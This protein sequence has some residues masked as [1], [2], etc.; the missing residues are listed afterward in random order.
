MDI[1]VS[2][3][4]RDVYGARA[5][6]ELWYGFTKKSYQMC[7]FLMHILHVFHQRFPHACRL[8]SHSA[9]ASP[10]RGPLRRVVVPNL[11]ELP[12]RPLEQ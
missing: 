10:V 5:K 11:D 4:E 6:C 7:V 1:G 2:H 12:R 9:P 8:F 3:G